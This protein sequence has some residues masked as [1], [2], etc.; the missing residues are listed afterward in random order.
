MQNDSQILSH[1][2]ITICLVQWLAE[3]SS[4]AHIALSLPIIPICHF[5]QPKKK[6]MYVY[7]YITA[8]H[9][10]ACCYFYIFLFSLAKR[11]D[12]LWFRHIKENCYCR[13]MIWIDL[14]S[15]FIRPS[16]YFTCRWWDDGMKQH[17][18]NIDVVQCSEIIKFKPVASRYNV[19]TGVHHLPMHIGRGHS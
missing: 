11:Y 17:N 16:L 6:E 19:V 3:H 13:T 10:F 12:V 1:L 7:I 2:T 9:Y 15:P 14:L 18:H 8:Y 4:Y 5:A